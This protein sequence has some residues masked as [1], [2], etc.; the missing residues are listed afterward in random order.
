[1]TCIKSLKSSST[2]HRTESVVVA[3][4]IIYW[5]N[6]LYVEIGMQVSCLSITFLS[7]IVHEI[8]TAKATNKTQWTRMAT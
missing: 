8:T 1:V 5:L 4:L 3:S 2:D 7:A 6:W